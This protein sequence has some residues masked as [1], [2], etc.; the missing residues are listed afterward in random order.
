MESG[1]RI[2]AW[3]FFSGC[4]KTR[5]ESGGHVAWDCETAA[6]NV[7]DVLAISGSVVSV[8]TCSYA[9]LVCGHKASPLVS[10]LVRTGESVGEYQTTLRVTETGPRMRIEF[11]SFISSRN[12]KLSKISDAGDLNV[13]DFVAL[14]FNEVGACNCAGRNETC[15]V[16]IFQAIANNYLFHIPNFTGPIS[17]ITCSLR[18][19]PETEIIYSIDVYILTF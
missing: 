11:T 3:C 9:E 19:S 12:Q 16:T 8:L 10:L 13:R 18:R 6:Q 1:T 4:A 14:D 5:I 17:F 7:I 15:A 2:D